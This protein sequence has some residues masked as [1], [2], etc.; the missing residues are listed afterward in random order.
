M[1]FG[2]NKSGKT[3]LMFTGLVGNET[4]E[5]FGKNEEKHY[6]GIQ[7]SQGFNTELFVRKNDSFVLWDVS[8]DLYHRQFWANYLKIIPTSIVLYVV[9][10]NESTERLQET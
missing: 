9:N 6:K 8:G 2:L 5:N 7:A 4:M 10:A 3:Q 1:M